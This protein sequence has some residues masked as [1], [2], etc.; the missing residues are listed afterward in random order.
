MDCVNSNITAQPTK[1]PTVADQIVHLEK[2]FA[3]YRHKADVF[4]PGKDFYTNITEPSDAQLMANKIFEWL[5]IK[6]HSLEIHID[7][8]QDQ[9]LKYS[10]HGDSKN[11]IL[12]RNCL[13][14]PLLAGAV[15]AHGICHHLLLSR[16]NTHLENIEENESLTDLGTI[17][18]GLGVLIINSFKSELAVLGSMA[19][20]NYIAE[21]K[22]YFNEKR[23][24]SN[25][26]HP[27]VMHFSSDY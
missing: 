14:N 22:D 3:S 1:L 15:I 5:G 7:P 17:Y 25:L 12:G 23:I 11:L 20:P 13:N 9:L 4:L 26:W 8:N 6:H 2:L 10:M 27:H 24:V 18:A 19:K 16:S 21:C